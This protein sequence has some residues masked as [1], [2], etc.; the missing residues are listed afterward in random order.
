MKKIWVL[1]P[2][3]VLTNCG[4][5]DL[6]DRSNLDTN[7]GPDYTTQDVGTDTTEAD[8]GLD[9][10]VV[11]EGKL[12]EPCETGLDCE[13]G[14]CRTF[15]DEAI[16]TIQCD[17]ECPA[18]GFVCF[19]SLCTPEDYC[20]ESGAGPGCIFSC[21]QCDSDAACEVAD[22]GE[23]TCTCLPGFSG[24]GLSCDANQCDTMPCSEDATCTET[25][26]G[27]SCECLSGWM[28]NGLVCEDID[29]CGDFSDNCSINA[30]C[31]NIQGSFICDCLPGFEGNGVACMDIDECSVDPTICGVGV[32]QN[33][34]GGY[35]CSCPMGTTFD[36]TTCT[37]GDACS[38]GL[39]DC[40]PNAQC[41]PTPNGY[42]CTCNAGYTGDGMTCAPI[43][44]CVPACGPNQVCNAAL[45]CE[46]SPGFGGPNC[47]DI[48][49]CAAGTDNCSANATCTNTVGSFACACNAGY[50]GN[51]VTCLDINECLGQNQ[52]SPLQTCTNTP[53]SYT[54]SC[55]PGTV[56][57]GNTCVLVGDVC[58]APFP[59]T[60]V[61]FSGS[62]NTFG[63]QSDYRFQGGQ[64]PGVGGGR[65]NNNVDQV[66]G[67]TPTVAA[68][69]RVSIDMQGWPGVAY[70]VT[71]CAQIGTTC[72]VADENDP[73]FTVAMSANQSYF[74]I[75][76]GVQ[77]R[78]G[79][80]TIDVSVDECA[81]GL[82]NCAADAI[83][84]DTLAGFECTCP[85]GFSGDGLFCIDLDECGMFAPVCDVNATCTNLPGTYECTCNAGYTGDGVTCTNASLPGETCINPFVVGALPYTFSGD[86]S[87]AA[88]DFGAAFNTCPGLV[89]GGGNNS[90]DEVFSFTP[91]ANATYRISL[92]TSWQSVLYVRTACTN[93]A[94]CLAGD[95]RAF[96][97][98]ADVDVTLLANVTYFIIVDGFGVQN[99]DGAY[100]LS[101]QQL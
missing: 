28:G 13:S 25:N 87:D 33:L 8:A 43:N 57:V 30:R 11:G 5:S 89:S 35:T 10:G 44:S 80:Y 2:L 7:G 16:C 29:E 68:T 46:C 51:G 6:F 62:N 49:E 94:A 100:T 32:C 78:T 90:N 48:N 85:S 86:T 59:I 53:G 65:G 12:G 70:V 18:P 67:F 50:T 14:I 27:F 71:D 99:V 75:V 26:D 1:L 36:G 88:N 72:L 98:S 63:F 22:T 73:D 37:G 92:A 47:V 42:Q 84:T 54:C 101:V 56:A 19:E 39:D 83:C 60:T 95:A 3:L 40:D 93:N 69:Y 82:D 96:S 81:S 20:P 9:I 45:Q 64:C 77:G 52:C 21:D 58:A 61:P 34:T 91:T 15:G 38:L 17:S 23:I 76:D 74:I 41:S 55:S 66:W 97:S 4:R 24:N 31:I 79:P